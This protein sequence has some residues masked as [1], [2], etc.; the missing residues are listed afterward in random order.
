MAKYTVTLSPHMIIALCDIDSCYEGDDS[1]R[2][3]GKTLPALY[4]RNLLMPSSALS[5]RGKA[6]LTVALVEVRNAKR[7][8][9]R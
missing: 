5:E 1:P 9:R 8:L 3:N 4:R 2:Y 6:Y 7:A